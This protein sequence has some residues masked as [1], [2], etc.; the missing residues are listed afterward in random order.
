MLIT[1]VLSG[2]TVHENRNTLLETVCPEIILL[3]G[4]NRLLCRAHDHRH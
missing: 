2:M 4:L 1:F 3:P